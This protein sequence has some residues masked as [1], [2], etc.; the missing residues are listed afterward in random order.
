VG[1]TE[2]LGDVDAC[3]PLSVLWMEVRHSWLCFLDHRC[4]TNKGL[5]CR[6]VELHFIA[7]KGLCK[8]IRDS[9]LGLG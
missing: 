5:A 7:L 6:M 1:M 9:W 4:R 8:T 3:G 2:R